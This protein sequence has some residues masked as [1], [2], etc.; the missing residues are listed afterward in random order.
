[1]TTKDKYRF[2]RCRR[3]V[4]A[5]P[6]LAAVP[7]IAHGKRSVDPRAVASMLLMGF[8]GKDD[9]SPSAVMLARDIDALGVG[10]ACFLGHNTKSRAGI[11]GLC[12]LFNTAG[13]HQA[14]FIAVDQEGG[15]VQRLN[16]KFGYQAFPRASVLAK[17]KSPEEAKAV[18]RQLAD[19][20]KR[21]GFN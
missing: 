7:Y 19:E 9:K 21:T 8:L 6:T 3:R 13:K 5:L 18:Y 1:M 20:L 11:E 15:A 12:R 2:N 14:A 10:G 16:K 4:L 17:N